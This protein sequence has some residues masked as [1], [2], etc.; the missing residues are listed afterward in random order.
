MLYYSHTYSLA[1]AASDPPPSS[2]TYLL[3]YIL[4]YIL[5]HL[6]TYLHDNTAS[7]PALHTYLFAHLL[8]CL[9]TH[10]PNPKPQT[11]N[12]APPTRTLTA[13]VLRFEQ[14]EFDKTH[15]HTP[16]V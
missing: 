8:A 1:V 14:T 9:T 12:V 13:S 7:N 15:A 11:P 16:R 6:P 10:S 2:I 3:T 4:T 5:P